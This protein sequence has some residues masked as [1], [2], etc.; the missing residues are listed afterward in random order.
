MVMLNANINVLVVSSCSKDFPW[1]GFTVEKRLLMI[2]VKLNSNTGKMIAV[3]GLSD[4]A[5]MIEDAAFG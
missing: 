1:K 2:P 4:A 5:L 3:Q